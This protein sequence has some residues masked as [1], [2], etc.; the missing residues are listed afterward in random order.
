MPS[1]RLLGPVVFIAAC[2]ASA[3]TPTYPGVRLATPPVID[4]KVE[5][6][7]WA[8]A[9]V[10][11]GLVDTN[12]NTP[13][14]DAAVFRMAYD[15]R[16]IYIAAV[17]ADSDPKSIR[18][19]EFRTNVDVSDDDSVEFGI[20][21]TNSLAESN[22]FSFNS[23]GATNVNLAGGRAAKREWL[24]DFISRG[25]VTENG[26]EAEARIPWSILRLPG[27]GKRDV[28]FNFYR[29]TPRTNRVFAHAFTDNGKQ[30]N[31]PIWQG[32]DLPAPTVDRSIKLLPYFY[33]GYDPDSGTVANAGL[34]L[35]TP[36]T[37]QIQL[38]GSINPDFRNIE[39]Q[40]LSLDFS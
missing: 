23:R 29:F 26:W 36:L 37:D 40:I 1:R 27:K 18:A 22:G 35:K 17:L 30:A 21:P 5:E 6:A 24:G 32:V 28:R 3:Q 38:V 8:G 25:R 2:Q 11:R 34:D 15:E 14:P 10:V 16:Y 7:E 12:N 9:T 4:G 33:G 13:A 31:T 19:V 39:N 20:D